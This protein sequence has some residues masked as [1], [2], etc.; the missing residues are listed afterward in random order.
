MSINLDVYN[1]LIRI[2]L[3]ITHRIGCNARRNMYTDPKAAFVDGAKLKS[4]ELF[5]N[6]QFSINELQDTSL[7]V[8][9]IFGVQI[10]D[11]KAELK[12]IYDESQAM[13]IKYKSSSCSLKDLYN[14]ISNRKE[15]FG[16]VFNHDWPDKAN[17][18]E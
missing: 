14:S 15:Y 18:D 7:I 17:Y 16:I 8:V 3:I 6:E 11:V 10:K 4:Y 2:L 12:F 1:N 13:D 5:E 9:D